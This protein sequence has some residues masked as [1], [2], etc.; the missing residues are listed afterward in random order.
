MQLRDLTVRRLFVASSALESKPPMT[1]L[2]SELKE[3][4]RPLLAE[5]DSDVV[6]SFGMKVPRNLPVQEP[7][8]GVFLK[9]DI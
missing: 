6:K 5:T 2:R 7:F 9:W 3:V 1:L 4:E 8:S